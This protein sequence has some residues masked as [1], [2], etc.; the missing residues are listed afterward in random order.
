MEISQKENI[1]AFVLGRETE[2]SLLE[3]KA[4]FLRF[5]FDFCVS[6]NHPEEAEDS[7]SA[8]RTDAP[9]YT[10]LSV[11]DNIAIIKFEK[12]DS[13]QQIAGSFIKQL[14][15]TVKIFKLVGL[16]NTGL[17]KGISDLILTAKSE[18]ATKVDFGISDYSKG[19]FD[20]NHLGLEV[21][22]ILKPSLKSRFIFVKEGREL[23]T[24]VSESNKLDDK[25][26]EVGIFS[27][28]SLFH[29]T[30]V[31][32]TGVSNNRTIVQSNNELYLGQLVALSDPFA[33]SKRDYGKPGGDKY[34]GMLPPKLARIMI[35]LAL[36]EASK[37]IKS[38]IANRKQIINSK[39]ENSK[40][41]CDLEFS[42][43]DFRPVV[44]DPFCGSG[45]IVIEA[46]I[47]GCDVVASDIS[48]K[49]VHNTESNLSWIKPQIL[50]SKSQTNS[51]FSNQKNQNGSPTMKQLNNETIVS[52]SDATKDD[53]LFPLQAK[54][55]K[56]AAI[57]AE[58]YLGEPKKFKPSKSAII[59]EF[60]KLKEEY[61]G[62]FGNL[63]NLLEAKSYKLSAICLVFP[64][65]ESSDHGQVSLFRESVD[66]I[67]NLGYTVSRP[68]L[69]YGRDYQVVKREIVLL[70]AP[71]TNRKS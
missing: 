36:N 57:V 64:L 71:A 6:K 69:V 41:V 44:V 3:L 20:I 40:N 47:L 62:F 49:A 22:K 34:S 59:G 68:P 2:L 11:T 63:A 16:S 53:F 31:E 32:N 60:N 1:F 56:L 27:I 58:P 61:L 39:K 23:T 33:W 21:K 5:D 67:K 42:A 9:S 45:N 30:T 8:S 55:Y 13:F 50:N 54:S 48:E 66:E 35:N 14:G 17:A 51:N 37:N 65:V 29:G 18:V 28:V 70:A 19:K 4:V 7:S 24:I 12:A 43:C 52:Q 38:Q 46:M 26:I 10:I 25:G 15:G